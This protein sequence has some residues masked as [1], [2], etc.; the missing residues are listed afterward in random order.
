[1]PNNKTSEINCLAT[2]LPA[3]CVAVF[4]DGS[5]MGTPRH[6]GAGAVVFGGSQSPIGEQVVKAAWA[7]GRGDN[8]KGEVVGLYHAFCF[9]DYL[10]EIYDRPKVLLFSDSMCSILYLTGGWPAPSEEQ[11]CRKMREIYARIKDSPNFR[12]YWIRGHI[13][14]TGNEMAD[15]QAKKGARHS[16]KYDTTIPTPVGQGEGELYELLRG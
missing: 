5:A 9:A 3:D 2:N 14:I 12:I 1:M 11:I 10:I 16:I 7:L 4:T 6:A 13:G 15:V 8:N